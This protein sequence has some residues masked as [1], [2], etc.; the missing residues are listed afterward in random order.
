MMRTV[1][2]PLSPRVAQ[3]GNPPAQLHVGREKIKGF[4]TPHS[5]FLFGGAI[6]ELLR[7]AMGGRRPNFQT[8]RW[9]AAEEVKQKSEY[10]LVQGKTIVENRICRLEA[11]SYDF[12]LRSPVFRKET[13]AV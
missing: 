11:Y 7:Q 5:N 3:K 6:L 8:W 4:L 9:L 12:S 1:A 2:G 10:R 13:V